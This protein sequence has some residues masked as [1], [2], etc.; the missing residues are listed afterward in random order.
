MLS[1]ALDTLAESSQPKS[2][3]WINLLLS[4]LR[5]YVDCADLQ[6]FM[7]EDRGTLFISELLDCLKRGAEEFDS[8]K[9]IRLFQYPVYRCIYTSPVV[10]YSNHPAISISV[11][12]DAKTC[13][14]E[15]GSFLEITLQNRLPC[16]SDHCHTPLCNQANKLQAL[17]V[18]RVSVI[19][20]GRD[21]EQI[22]YTTAAQQLDPGKTTLTL[23]CPVCTILW[24]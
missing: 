18:N 14:S 17:P 13:D 10:P 12:G 19:L 5:T 4:F 15:D 3:E 22:I 1:R 11:A 16:V 23:F 8:G 21:A 2:R 20:T 24:H 9:C 6:S 7:Y